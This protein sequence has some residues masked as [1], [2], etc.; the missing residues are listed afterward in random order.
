MTMSIARAE[1]IVEQQDEAVARFVDYL[2]NPGILL[3]F[4]VAMMAASDDLQEGEFSYKLFR[5]LVKQ[6]AQFDGGGVTAA[7]PALAML[8]ATIGG[9]VKD[10]DHNEAI[11]PSALIPSESTVEAYLTLFHE[12]MG[13]TLDSDGPQDAPANEASSPWAYEES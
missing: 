7:A 6:L 12:G 3:Y 5:R 1:A 13:Y 8:V 4:R 2:N 11:F 10:P 9:L